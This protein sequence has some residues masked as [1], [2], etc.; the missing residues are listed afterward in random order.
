MSFAPHIEA[1]L[2]AKAASGLTFDEIAQKIGK[3]EVWTAALFYGNHVCDHETSQKIWEAL[4]ANASSAVKE[5]GV[6]PERVLKGLTGVNG[7]EGMANRG[8]GM[9]M[10]PRD[11]T[12]YRLYEVLLVYGFSYKALIREKFGDGIMSAI[13]F[14][15]TLERKETEDGPRVVITLDGKF[16]PYTSPDKW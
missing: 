2:A 8:Q 14:R 5:V 11:P 6:S 13:G 4:G 1:L 3:P 9:E 15:T 16:L 12:L 10:P 7:V